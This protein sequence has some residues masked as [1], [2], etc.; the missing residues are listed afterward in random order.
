[1]KVG[2]KRKRVRDEAGDDARP[3]VSGSVAQQPAIVPATATAAAANQGSSE[4]GPHPSGLSRKERRAAFVKEYIKPAPGPGG[5]GGGRFR[6]PEQLPTER[7][8]SSYQD[9]AAVVPSRGR[10]GAAGGGRFGRGF[11]QEAGGV[12]D[13]PAV[14]LVKHPFRANF[15]DHFE[16]DLTAVKDIVPCLSEFRTL[17]RPNCPEAFS[18]YDPYYCNGSVVQKW[19]SLGFLKVIHDNRDFYRDIVDGAIPPYDILVTNPPFSDDHIP[20][21]FEFLLEKKKPF[22]VLMPDY[23]ATKPWYRKLIVENFLPGGRDGFPKFSFVEEQ[24]Q[25]QAEGNHFYSTKAKTEAA[26][27]QQGLSREE[28]HRMIALGLA[29]PPSNGSAAADATTVTPADKP[30]ASPPPSLGVEPFYVIPQYRYQFEHPEG[31]GRVGGS[32][33]KT[34]WY[35][36]LGRRTQD[37]VRALQAKEPGK[38]VERDSTPLSTTC[39]HGLSA[40]EKR[41]HPPA[42]GAVKRPATSSSSGGNF[43]R[44]EQPYQPQRGNKTSR[45]GAPKRW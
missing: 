44:R 45:Q 1:M 20:K 27:P 40:L 10:G 23:V 7:F 5:R 4:G 31:V 15:N 35:V 18:L 26:P 43:Q 22:A 42:K 25:D 16:T 19:N 33:F 8:Q 11:G 38:W 3:P 41:L 29:D 30:S 17:I 13:R 24:D 2:L 14:G 6:E 12:S 39:V 9:S 28:Q 34:M 32:H 21:L 37:V 36:W